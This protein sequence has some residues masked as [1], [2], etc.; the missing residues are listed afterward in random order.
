MKKSVI[1]L[2]AILS[3]FTTLTAQKV[4][5]KKIIDPMDD[6]PF[7]L[8]S[9]DIVLSNASKTKGTRMDAFIDEKNGNLVFGDISVRMVNIGGCVENNEL[10]ILFEDTTKITL[11]SWN[12]F[13]CEGNAWFHV[14]ED[15]A[16]KLATLK[17]KKIKITNGSTYD[18]FT[19]DIKSA[20][21][22]YYI[23]VYNAVKNK[24]IKEIKK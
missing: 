14:S 24:T 7:Y 5:I 4:Y 17:M 16:I 23:Q 9:N 2:V 1:T 11:V 6:A 21:A 13:N 8:L 15:E 3:F 22:D 19:S 18:S 10:V 12:K 20:D